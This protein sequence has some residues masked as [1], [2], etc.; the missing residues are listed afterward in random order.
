MKIVNIKGEIFHYSEQLKELNKFGKMWLIIILKVTKTGL[1]PL[2]RKHVFGK[3]LGWGSN[4]PPAFLG[5]IFLLR[6]PY[7]Q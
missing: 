5:L 1:H 6:D 2:S 7:E 3:A 4:W